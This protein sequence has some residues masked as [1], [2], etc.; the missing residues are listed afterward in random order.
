MLIMV[1]GFVAF[2]L[3]VGFITLTKS[4]LQVAA[5]AAAHSASMELQPQFYKDSPLTAAEAETNAR[6]EAVA[7]AARHKAGE[8]DSVYADLNRDVRVGNYSYDSGTGTWVKQWGVAPYNM[9]EVT[10][11]RDQVSAA[12]GTP[13]AGGDKPLPLFFAPVIGHETAYLAEK[14]TAAILAGGGFKVIPGQTAG[15]LPITVEEQ[16]WDNLI[17]N[18]IGDDLWTYNEE[19][20]EVTAGADGIREINLYPAATGSSGNFGTVDFGGANNSTADLSRQ[21][22]YGLNESDLSYFPNGELRFDGVPMELNGDTGI[23]AGIKDELDAIMGQPRA[24]P[25]YSSVVGNG[26]NATYTI[27]KFV[28]IR[29]V[30]VK[31]TGGNKR[32]VVQPAPFSD[33]SVVPG[34]VMVDTDNTIFTT[35]RM[36]Q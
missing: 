29:I 33:H 30:E 15:V 7:M 18:N 25:V 22:L 31:L 23:S 12:D 28:G 1:M 26:N 3:D 14:S 4:Q 20:G 16:T 5:D 10:L 34:N 32:V 6:N 36:I 21:I 19:T 8:R 13:N 27:V 35:A 11:R 24:I 9:V 17:D 2:T